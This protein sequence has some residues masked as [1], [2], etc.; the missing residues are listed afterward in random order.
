MHGIIFADLK[1]FVKETY[2]FEWEGLLK[3]SDI[4]FKHY[5]PLNEYPD[6]EIVSL[7][8]IIARK[9]GIESSEILM[10]FGEHLVPTLYAMY[11]P[12]LKPEW[13]TL[14]VIEN[15]EE[16]IHSVVRLKNPGAHPPALVC[17][18]ESLD[19]V[20]ILYSSDRKMCSVAKGITKGLARYFQEKIT[21]SEDTCM[22]KSDSVCR[23]SVRTG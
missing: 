19:E 21:L 7:I 4:G 6:S 16:T 8:R 1:K 3:E 20:V 13:K 17:H 23:I 22:L 15:V 9:T 11:K 14:D 10:S 12:L 18:R 5:L 2:G